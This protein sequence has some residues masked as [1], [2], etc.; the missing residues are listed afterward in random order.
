[1]SNKHDKDVSTRGK[2]SFKEAIKKKP[3]PKQ[4]NLTDQINREGDVGGDPVKPLAENHVVHRR[5]VPTGDKQAHNNPTRML[6]DVRTCSYLDLDILH[7]LQRGAGK[8]EVCK[9]WLC[10]TRNAEESSWIQRSASSWE[11]IHAQF[12]HDNFNIVPWSYIVSNGS[13]SQAYVDRLDWSEAL[14]G[15]AFSG[16]QSRVPCGSFTVNLLAG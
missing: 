8:Q 7:T 16:L 1:M 14:G 5:Q 10:S 11:F 4:I 6:M 3:K 15:A 9:L 12:L 13:V 2:N